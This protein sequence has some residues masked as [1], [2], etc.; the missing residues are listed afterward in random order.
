[1]AQKSVWYSFGPA[2]AVWA[3]V[4]HL[5]IKLTTDCDRTCS[6]CYMTL[7]RRYM[8]PSLFHKI[9]HHPDVSQSVRGYI[10]HGGEPTLYPVEEIADDLRFL[11][12]SGKD[13]GMTTNGTD[14]ERVARFYPY[15]RNVCVS[16][17]P[18][19]SPR[20]DDNYTW[21]E[22]IRNLRIIAR[23]A[24]ARNVPVSALGIVTRKWVE[25]YD[26][27]LE[28]AA[29][30]HELNVPWGVERYLGDDP[31]LNLSNG[32]FLQF[33]LKMYRDFR[34]RG[35]KQHLEPPVILMNTYAF[36][37]GI[38]AVPSLTGLGC[39][40]T[41]AVTVDPD[42]YCYVCAKNPYHP[43]SVRF[44]FEPWRSFRAFTRA[45][46]A[47]AFRKAGKY[48]DNGRCPHYGCPLWFS[49][50]HG[51]LWRTDDRLPCATQLVPG[52]YTK[53]YLSLLGRGQCAPSSTLR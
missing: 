47:H 50:W 49:C 44:D 21:E 14:P 32:E 38:L 41:G 4:T 27:V 16:T 25:E 15:L 20:Y 8:S 19:F 24:R 30:L 39:Q 34:E 2:A 52:H 43:V 5:Q 17:D 29:V 45:L 23:E 18:P 46:R 11:L 26:A 28:T 13:V 22:H 35:F 36:D 42:G 3:P 37:T 31:E 48:E 40:C 33:M 51:C 9:V 6:F 1:M 53:E 12:G 7:D 10:L